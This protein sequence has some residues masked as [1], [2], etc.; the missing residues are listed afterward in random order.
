MSSFIF[1]TGIHYASYTVDKDC[2]D[3]S[4]SLDVNDPPPTHEQG[5]LSILLTFL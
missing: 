4:W 2:A 1:G 5:M 3:A